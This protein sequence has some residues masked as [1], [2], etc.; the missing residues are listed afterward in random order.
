MRRIRNF[1]L[2]ELLVVIAIIAI[3][4]SMLLPA[5]SKA[6]AA[7][8]GIKCVSN[9]KQIGMYVHLY[10]TDG[11]GL[12]PAAGGS[13]PWGSTAANPGWT[14]HLNLVV[15][16]PKGIFKCPSD[17]REFSYSLN[18][19][20]VYLLLGGR[21]GSWRQNLFDNSAVGASRIILIEESLD[22]FEADDSDLDNYSQDTQP[23]KDLHSGF[24]LLFADN[25][26]E[27]VKSYDFHNYGYY[28]DVLRSKWDGTAL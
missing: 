25:H 21:F 20:E 26:V 13:M 17:T 9:Q 4:A 14:N 19:H 2:I 27:K 6:R 3:L 24:T 11:D 15:D 22:I 16:A 28:T 1:T 18:C 7:A 10:Q 12:Y 8:Q 23:T 5:L